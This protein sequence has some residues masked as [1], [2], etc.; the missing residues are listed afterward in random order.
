MLSQVLQ[1]I[2]KW[3]ASWNMVVEWPVNAASLV[4]Q[5]TKASW[6]ELRSGGQVTMKG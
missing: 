2:K 4:E 5:N 6:Y 1:Q 3:E